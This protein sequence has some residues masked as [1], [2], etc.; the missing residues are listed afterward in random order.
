MSTSEAPAITQ[1]A[2][3]KLVADSVATALEAQ[4]ATMADNTNRNTGEREAPV[5]RQLFSRSNCTEDCKVKFATG[6]LTEEALSWWN[7]FAQPIG[8]EEAYKITWGNDLKA[9]VRRSQELATLC[10][11]MVPDSEKMMEVFIGGLPRSIEGNVTA[12]KPQTLEETIN[13]ALRLMDQVT[14]HT[15]VKVS[16]DHKQKF[17][18]RR[19]F[20]NNNYRNT[21]TN[22]RYNNHQPQQNRRQ[23]TF[24]AYAATPTENNRYTGNR[25][26]CKKCTL[27]HTGPCTCRKTTNNNA[28]GRAYM[29]RDRNAQQ[30]PNVVTGSSVYSKIDLR[31]GYHQL[32]VRD[33]DIPKTAFR[34]R[35][36]HYEF[37]VML[38]GLTNAPAVFMALMN[39]D[40]K[41]LYWWP[42]MKAII[43]E[44]VGKCLT[45]SRV[46]AECQKPSSLLGSDNK[47]PMLENFLYDS[48]KSIMELYMMNKPH[49]RMI[50]ASVEK[51]PLVW[52]SITVDGVTRLKEYTELT[53]TEA[54]QADCDIKAINIILQGLLT[55][56]YALVSQH[57][58]AKDLW[59][60]IKLLMQGTSLTKQER[61]LTYPS[62]DFQSSIHHNVYSPSSSIPQLEYPPQINQQSEF[63]QQDSG[64]IVPVF[65]KGDDPIDAINHMMSFLT[66]VVTSRYPTTNNQLRNSSNPRQ[67]ATINNG[68][69]TLQPI[70]G[71]QTSFCLRYTSRT[72]TPGA[73]GSNSGKQRTVICYN[74]KGEGHMS[75]QCTKPKRK[76]DDS[77][78]KEKV[79]LVQAQAHGQILNEE[80]LAFL[81]DL[82]IPEGQGIQTVI[83]HNAAYQADDL[84]AYDSDCDELNSA[85]VALMANLSHYGSDA[86]AENSVN[87]FEPTLSIRPTN[88]EVPKEVPNDPELH[89]VNVEPITPKLLNKRTAHSAYIKH[90]QEEAAVLRDLV[91]HI[92]AN[93][94][95]DPLLESACKYTKLIQ[96]MLSKISKT[97]PSINSSGEQLVAVTP[98]NKVKRVRFT[99]PVTS[100][101][102]TKTAH[103]SNLASNKPMLSSTGVKQSTSASGS[104]PSGNTKKDKIQQTQS[105]ILKNKVEA[106]PRKVKSSL[107]NKD[108][109]VAPKGTA[110]VQH[111]KLNANY[112]LKCVK[113]NGCMLSDNHD[114]CVLDFINNV[115]ARAKS[116]SVKKNSKRKVWKPTGKVFT[117]IGYIWRPT[118]RTFTIVG[119]A[120]PLT[121]ITTT[122]EVPLRKSSALDN[123]TPKPVVTL[124]YS[125]KP[126]KSK[127]SVPVN[128]YKVIKSVTANNLE[129][130]QSRGS[131]VSN[132]PSSSFD[133]CSKDYGLWRLSDWECYNFKEGVDLLTGSRG[134]NLYTLSLGDMMASSPI[135]LLSKASK[136]KSWLWHRRLSHL[137]FEAI[138]HLARHG[139]V[140]GLPKLKFENDHLC[141]ACALG[142]SMKKPHKP[143]SEDT[144]QEKLYLLHMDLCGPMR[145][146]S[147]NGK[148]YILVIVD[149]YSRF[150]CVKCLRSKNEA[151]TFIINFLKMIQLT[152]MASEHSSSGPA[153]HD[154]TPVTISSGLVPNPHPSTPFVPPSRIDW[155]MLFQPLFDEFLN[156]SPS[157]DHPAPEVVAPSNE[158]IALVLADSAG[159]P[160]STTVD[161]DAPSPSNSQTTPETEP[162]IIP[163]DVEEDNHDIEVAHMGNDPYFG[164]PILEIPSDQS[165]SSDSIHTIFP[166]SCNYMSKLLSVT[167]M[168]SSLLLNPR[169]ART[170]TRQSYDD[171]FEVDLQSETRRTGRNFEESFAPV[172]RLE[173]IR[174]FLAFVA[175]MNKV[176]YQMDVKTA[177]LNGNMQEEVYV[178]QPDGFVDKDNPNHVYKLK[179]ALYGL[180]QAPRAWYDMLSSFLISQDFSKG[181]VDPTLFIRRDGKELLLV[182]IYVD[183]II[184]A[185]STP[186][187]CDL[188]SK[189]MCSKFKMSMMG[190]ISFFLGLQISQ[191]PRGIII[192][193]S[194]Y[195][196]E[197]LKKYSFDSYDPVDTPMVEKSKLDE[198]KEGK[199]VD[200][201]HYRGMIGT[202]LY[203]TTSRPDLQ[204]AICM[205]ARY[206]ARPTEKHLNAVKRIFRYLKG[207]VHRGL[208]YPKDSSIALTTFADADHAGCQDTRRSTFGS[209][210]LLGDRLVSWSSKRQKSAAISSTEAEYI[211][212][213]GCCAQILWMRSQLTDYGFGFNKI[214]M[215]CDNKSAIALCCN[216]VQHSRSK[217]IDIRFHFIKEHVENGVIELYF[218]NTEYQLADIFTKALGRNRI[219][220]LINKLGMRSFTPETLKQL[221]DEVDE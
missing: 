107:K 61:E 180:K 137:N 9:Y 38:F 147:V 12:S 151:P 40:L 192:N 165:L 99:E 134:D 166:L 149:D 35:Y 203:L 94:P 187:L 8:I 86:L 101:R 14:K 221:A 50:L 80:E 112:E 208:W 144:N 84:D 108:C 72:Y 157:V 87:S 156:P 93:Y 164:V 161:Q 43:A 183:D 189:I 153:L 116:R 170:P 45:C 110:H 77:W 62:N 10:P 141:S 207:T 21:N 63:S 42:N 143:K 152:A 60:K 109:V 115:N 33:E 211:A 217:H 186:E 173:A 37:Q 81:A 88:V 75:R 85:K 70:Q 5:A 57:R 18:D 92:K 106:H 184:F 178:S 68:R 23:E 174:I 89:Q 95:L 97:C 105:R 19:T 126:R 163:N 82:D 136:T 66:A 128:N 212:L 69:V 155:D 65:Q 41:K 129:P 206:Q 202:L 120:C 213:S 142:K 204:F 49:G 182:Q 36:G 123:K 64:L 169:G 118:G 171:Y 26:L 175:H 185:A 210:Q 24:K 20:N 3:R 196:L 159:S 140:R 22:N 15:L 52:P 131:I 215:Y 16:S 114:L 190:K 199:A 220:F 6:T 150:T 7:Y 162:P 2:I 216:N 113:C 90:S 194:K 32:R 31:S 198:D 209:M 133:E 27:H 218:V 154:M 67:Q 197:S 193:Q 44:Y 121:R 124:V 39:R 71:R 28:Q 79:L 201:S 160:S 48:W 191:N 13:I 78:F 56:I 214:P 91:D 59:E 55:E 219:E 29:L 96:E 127:T 200:P 25:P 148:K 74:C 54:I 145:V 30:N 34:T 177:F 104:Q 17:D 146:A 172:A 205:C 188:F 111:S 139:L 76:R 102:N 179:K 51:G 168:L 47:P 167:T 181:S 4:A 195:A 83:T 100:S 11:T 122:T 176:V 53:P 98:M 117:N 130:S 138:N 73:S 132:V 158:V 46:K 1:A 135:C 119:N 103:T 58:V 125:R